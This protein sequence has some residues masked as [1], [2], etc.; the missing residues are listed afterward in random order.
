M[1]GLLLLTLL[2]CFT[3]KDYDE[4]EYFSSFVALILGFTVL[5]MEDVMPLI[6]FAIFCYD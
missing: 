6:R 1:M 5:G 2:V 4:E 3:R